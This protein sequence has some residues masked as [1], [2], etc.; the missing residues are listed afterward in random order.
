LNR[1][2]PINKCNKRAEPTSLFTRI[3]VLIPKLTNPFEYQRCNSDCYH[4][5]VLEMCIKARAVAVPRPYTCS[6]DNT[7]E[8]LDHRIGNCRLHIATIV[9]PTHRQ[10]PRQP[11]LALLLLTQGRHPEACEIL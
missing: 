5:E 7:A 2:V 10:V 11:I 1:H 3:W 4:A 8:H 6:Q 9:Q